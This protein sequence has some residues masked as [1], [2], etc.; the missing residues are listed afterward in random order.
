MQKIK[1]LQSD[2]YNVYM[3]LRLEL[4][5]IDHPLLSGSCKGKSSSMP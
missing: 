3:Y 5:D 1:S 2:G 4:M